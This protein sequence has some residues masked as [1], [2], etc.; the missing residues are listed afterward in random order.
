MNLRTLSRILLL[1]LLAF[2]TALP[3]LA[4]TR[5]RAIRFSPPRPPEV[6]LTGTVLDD[7]TGAPVVSADVSVLNR[8]A[9]TT[10][11]ALGKFVVNVPANTQVTIE[12]SR[13][14]YQTLQAQVSIPAEG[15]QQFRLA[16]LTTVEVRMASGQIYHVDLE[17]V[18]FGY[19]TGP[20]TGYN[21]S[22]RL[23]LCK[24]GGSSFTPDRTAIQ[25]ITGP[26]T[27]ATHSACCPNAQLQ[28]INIE[29]KSGESTQAFLID[30][31]NAYKIDLVARDHTTFDPVYLGLAQI[32]EIKFP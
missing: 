19:I 28:A 3:M 21:K 20:F 17:T 22:S 15:T 7:V 25:R 10:T 9:F 31:C 12:I 2:A 26:A 4:T 8:N 32:A 11:D 24:P 13:V 27:A 18:E 23:N 16:A 29:L 14:G 5:R 30:T 1:T 6:M